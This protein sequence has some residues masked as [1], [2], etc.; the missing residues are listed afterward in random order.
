MGLFLNF[1]LHKNVL[2]SLFKRQPLTYSSDS[3]D[4]WCDRGI[5]LSHYYT[6]VI[7][8]P[9]IGASY[10]FPKWAIHTAATQEIL[11]VMHLF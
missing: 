2:E 6:Q 4:L 7:L 10:S 5:C 3:V 9:E 11:I 1:R 8:K